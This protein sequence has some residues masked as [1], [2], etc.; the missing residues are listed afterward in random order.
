MPEQYCSISYLKTFNENQNFKKVDE[1]LFRYLNDTSVRKEEEVHNKTLYLTQVGYYQAMKEVKNVENGNVTC[2][3]GEY[4]SIAYD[5]LNKFAD[6]N[7]S[8]NYVAPS[9][10]R[11]FKVFD[12]LKDYN[13]SYLHLN[14]GEESTLIAILKDQQD[15]I[16]YSPRSSNIELFRKN[17]EYGVYFQ[18]DE[19]DK[20]INSIRNGLNEIFNYLKVDGELLFILP[21]INLKETKLVI[22]EFMKKHQ[23]EAEVIKEKMYLPFKE[24]NSLLY[25]AL[26]RKIK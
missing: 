9:F 22:E 23:E 2:F 1:G 20:I 17:P 26:I 21:T 24:E 16:L 19:M 14:E 3:L 12:R 4:N 7:N 15:F 5:F 6:K 18:V 8:L 25:Y 11:V 13:L 10:E